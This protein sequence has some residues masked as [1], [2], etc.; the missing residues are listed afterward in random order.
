MTAVLVWKSWAKEKVYLL[1]LEH[2]RRT[3]WLGVA[4]VRKAGAG[5]GRR[6]PPGVRVG[7]GTIV[8]TRAR[9]SRR[10][11]RFVVVVV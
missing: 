7:V 10:H 1:V 5:G 6:C 9:D 4:V 8:D 11:R 3:V 2:S